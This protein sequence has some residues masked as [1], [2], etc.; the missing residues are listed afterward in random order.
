MKDSFLS[1]TLTSQLFKPVIKINLFQAPVPTSF[2]FLG[3]IVSKYLDLD[4]FSA[5]NCMI[6]CFIKLHN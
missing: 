6:W 3:R 5:E 4:E 2:V 1:F